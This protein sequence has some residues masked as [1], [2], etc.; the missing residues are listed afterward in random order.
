LSGLADDAE[1]LRRAEG[2]ESD[3]PPWIVQWLRDLITRAGWRT[4]KRC[5]EGGAMLVVPELNG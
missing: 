4:H 1:R 3:D 2:L 5:T